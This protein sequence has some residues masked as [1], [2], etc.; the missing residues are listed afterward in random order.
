MP[1]EPSY[2]KVNYAIR[3]AKNIER[4]M[5]SEML[6]RLS[7]FR[8][9][10]S[11]RYIGMGSTFYSDFSLFHRNLGM[12]P[13]FSI[14]RHHGDESRFD[15]NV[16]LGCVKNRFGDSTQ[17][18]PEFKWKEVPTIVWLDYD[19]LLSPYM[20]DDIAYLTGVLYPSSV[21]IVTV[22][23][24]G[25]EFG[26]P[27]ER[28]K[29]MRESIRERLPIDIT[30]SELLNEVFHKVVRRTIRAVIDDVLIRRN[31]G[32]QEKKQIEFKQLF[33]F[34]YADTTPMVTIGGLFIKRGQ[35][36]LFSR[37][38]F[39]SLKFCASGEVPYEIYAP[40]LTFTERRF[41]DQQ[42]PSEKLELPGIPRRDLEAYAKLYRYFPHFVEAE[43]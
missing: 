41:L 3:P 23:N 27:E 38:D 32:I 35:R 42:L 6:S 16:P 8:R 12:A 26:T 15:F 22:R 9:V 20:L 28:L 40:N 19:E 34:T 30:P 37:C 31:S 39:Q 2:L 29:N 7:V 43:L 10:K 11:Y 4:K 24:R 17:V 36:R 21:L 1:D 14:Q 5:M 33:Y 18:L 25:D 13:M